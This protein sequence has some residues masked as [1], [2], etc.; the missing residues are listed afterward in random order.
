MK[1][2]QFNHPQSPLHHQIVTL[3]FLEVVV[4]SEEEEEE[5]ARDHLDVRLSTTREKLSI[6]LTIRHSL[7]YPLLPSKK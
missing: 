4:D 6:F 3:T 5:E 1:F 2:L 7:N